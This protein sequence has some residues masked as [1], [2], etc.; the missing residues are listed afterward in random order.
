MALSPQRPYDC[1]IDLLPGATLPASRLYNV[2]HPEKEAMEK[3]ITVSLA[4]GLIRPSFSPLGADF[5][6]LLFFFFH[7]LTTGVSMTFNDGLHD[8]LNHFVFVYLDDI[9]IISC[10]IEEHT[11][12]VRLALQR[13]LKN[14]LYVK[15]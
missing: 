12:H 1:V 11:Q 10:S 7:A 6:F 5:F 9:L 14:K 3:Y 13:L 8:M 2:S 15:P 4:A